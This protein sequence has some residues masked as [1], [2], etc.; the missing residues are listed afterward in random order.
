[1][2]KTNWRRLRLTRALCCLPY[3]TLGRPVRKP[4]GHTVGCYATNTARPTVGCYATNS[5]G[6]VSVSM[7]I[8]NYSCL[9][10]AAFGQT[11][12]YY[13]MTGFVSNRVV[14]LIW[15]DGRQINKC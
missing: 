10:T 4:G 12:Q 3:I 13:I 5:T 11:R 6:V 8:F 7:E 1:M 14:D 15:I 2:L 9:V